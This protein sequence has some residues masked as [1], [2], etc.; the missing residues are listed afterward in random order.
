MSK[1][2]VSKIIFFRINI[3]EKKLRL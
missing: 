3:P 2:Q 1:D